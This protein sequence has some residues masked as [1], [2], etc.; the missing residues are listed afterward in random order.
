MDISEA[1]VN[2]V[3]V[4][5]LY[6]PT[7]RYF[8]DTFYVICT[9][10][11]YSKR[12]QNFIVQ[13]KDPFRNEW[14]EPIWVDFNGIDPSLFLDDGKVYFQGSLNTRDVSPNSPPTTVSQFEIDLKTGE[15]LSGAP[16]KMWD[17]ISNGIAP[18][19]P[20]VYKKDG[21]YYLLI[22]EG[23]TEMGH[24]VTMARSRDIWGPYEGHPE[25]PVLTNRG[26]EEYIQAVGHAELFQDQHGGWWAVALAIRNF[27]MGRE[28]FLCPVEWPEGEWPIFNSRRPLRAQLETDRKLPRSKALPDRHHNASGWL[29]PLPWMFLRDVRREHYHWKPNKNLILLPSAAI[30]TRLKGHRRL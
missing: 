28:T 14:S 12:A 20:H 4:A 8:N 30:L 21:W 3:H 22:A 16:K 11:R 25:N 2:G 29:F 27:S 7:I 18:E 1:V 9:N 10:V 5:G 6:A 17:G 13:S 15:S 26:T 23:G 19:G 24:M